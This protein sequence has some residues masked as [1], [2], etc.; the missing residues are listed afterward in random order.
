M[1]VLSTI[2]KPK[3]RKPVITILGDSGIGKTTLAASFENPIILRAEDGLQAIPEES[4]PDALPVIKKVDMLW[5]Q[6][7]ALVKE[8]HEYKTLVIDSVTALERL[9]IQHI[10]DTDKNNPRSINQAMGGYGNGPAAVATMHQ[11]VRNACGLL[12]ER[13]MTI[14][15]IA[16]A[17]SENVDPPDQ[18]PYTRYSLRLSKKSMPMYVDDS[19]VVGFLKLQMFIM[20]NEGEKKKAKS[21]GSRLLTCYTSAANVSKNRYGITTDLVVE[22][23]KNPLKEFIPTL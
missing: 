19:D 1:S 20:G 2:E 22:N 11:R 17:E 18:D 7:T 13:G 16:H 15:F 4:R 3:D 23:G 14:I 10:M 21:D 12:N 5:E 6:L 8:E 9:F